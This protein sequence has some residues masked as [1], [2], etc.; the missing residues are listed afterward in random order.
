M[1][2]LKY[3]SYPGL[4]VQN[5]QNFHYNQAVRIPAGADRIEIAGQGMQ[6]FNVLIHTQR[7]FTFTTH[8]PSSNIRFSH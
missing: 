7:P 6:R 3:N 2:H 8:F 5:L 1:S 4:G